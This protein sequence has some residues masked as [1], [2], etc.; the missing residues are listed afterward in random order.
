MKPLGTLPYHRDTCHVLAFANAA[1]TAPPAS[2]DESDEDE[3]EDDGGLVRGRDRW[4][5]TGGTDA[6]VAVWEL[7]DFEAAGKKAAKQAKA[8]GEI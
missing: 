8:D 1:T 6:R 7:M 4:L 5:T 2:G 3:D